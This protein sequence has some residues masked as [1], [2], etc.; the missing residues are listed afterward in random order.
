MS[1]EPTHWLE[2]THCVYLMRKGSSYRVGRTRL[3]TTG[4]STAQG[5]LHISGLANRARNEN[6]DAI[7]LLQASRDARKIAVLELVTQIGYNLPGY[8]FVEKGQGLGIAE[9]FW[10]IIGDNTPRAASCL[11]AFGLSLF[12]PTWKDGDKR[13]HGRN[14]VNFLLERVPSL[15]DLA[16][17][18]WTPPPTQITLAELLG[19]E[20]VEPGN[21]AG[22]ET[23]D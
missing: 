15:L 5:H 20:N 7:W 23:D 18:D 14:A 2:E 9:E 21:S 16:P 8:C 4:Y 11:R 13:C 22:C 3:I 6:A 17:T 1:K 19:D 12:K 10:Q